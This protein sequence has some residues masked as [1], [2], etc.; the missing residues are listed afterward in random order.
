MLDEVLRIC[1][2]SAT[3]LIYDFEIA[4]EE[5]LVRLNIDLS[6][7]KQSA[8]NHEVDFSGLLNTQLETLTSNKELI[9]F[10]ISPSNIVHLLLSSIDYYLVLKDTFGIMDLEKILERHI[11]TLALSQLNANIYYKV[12]RVSKKE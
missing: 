5:I 10:T 4:L 7:I 2:N 1:K 11:E 9:R 12:Y 3:I 8:Y 6:H